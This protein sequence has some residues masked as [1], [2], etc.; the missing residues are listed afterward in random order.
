MTSAVFRDE[1]TALRVFVPWRCLWQM[2]WCSF[3][4]RFFT[5]KHFVRAAASDLKSINTRYSLKNTFPEDVKMQPHM[6]HA[7]A[8]WPLRIITCRKHDAINYGFQQGLKIHP[9][10]VWENGCCKGMLVCWSLLVFYGLTC[11]TRWCSAGLNF[12]HG[13]QQSRLNKD[14]FNI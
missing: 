8:E 2:K 1:H 11:W 6:C 7:F 5:L 3:I 9:W 13:S 12:K 14:L 10:Y 4:W